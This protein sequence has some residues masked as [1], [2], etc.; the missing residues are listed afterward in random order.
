M[1]QPLAGPPAHLDEQLFCVASI[2]WLWIVEE[3]RP[4]RWDVTG[5]SICIVG[6]VVIFLAPRPLAYGRAKVRLSR[7]ARFSDS[8]YDWAKFSPAGCGQMGTIR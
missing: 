8:E 2:L 5:A 3:Q 1:A 6:A 7:L 4:D